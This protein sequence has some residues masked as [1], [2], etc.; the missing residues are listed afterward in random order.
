MK[1]LVIG[2]GGREHAIAD[3][4]SRSENADKIYVAPGNGGIS[5]VLEAVPLKATDIQGLRDFALD[6]KIDLTVVGPEDPLMLGVA[7]VFAKAGL[8][9][10][11][12]S[13]KAALIEGSKVFTREFLRRAKVPQPEFQIFE[14]Y[15]AALK[16]IEKAK[17]PLVLKADGLAAGK[18]V[19]IAKDQSEA[20][21]A[22]KSIMIA[23]T[24]GQAG[25]KMLVEEC[26]EGKEVSFFIITDGKTVLPLQTAQDYKRLGDGDSGPNTGGMG[27]YSPS[28]FLTPEQTTY[29]MEKIMT[30]VVS[31]LSDEEREYKGFLYGGLMITDA[32]IKVLEFNCRMG[33][34]EGEVLLPRIEGDIIPYL[35]ASADG[36]LKELPPLEWKKESSVTVIIASK[37]Y[38]GKPETGFEINGLEDAG[39]L[40][41]V[42]VFHS[43]SGLKDSRI[44]NTGGRVLA[45]TALG[46][47]ISEARSRAYKAVSRISFEGMQYRKD[48]AA[49]AVK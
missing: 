34:P 11:G 2:G 8:K 35:I 4:L 23:K 24:F 29:I 43:G 27:C 37:G 45:V 10:F 48:I 25:N 12:P 44:V 20:K 39:N 41:G 40:T 33:D 7:D 15:S 36:N 32:G 42:K 30:P 26:L 5:G 38:P 6:K 46:E 31:S 1:I 13:A 22:V 9:V 19:F 49:D 28:A 3:L 18:G 21:E 14:D 16:Y 17:T 47:D